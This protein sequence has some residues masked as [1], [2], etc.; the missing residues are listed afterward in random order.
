MDLRKISTGILMAALVAGESV[1]GPLD[2]P[3]DDKLTGE[4]IKA[5]WFT[6][7][8]FIATAPDGTAYRFVFQPD[9]HATK[10]PV[11][12]APAAKK[13]PAISGFWRIIAEGYCVRWTG[14][15]REKCF[16]IRKEGDTTVARF[17][18]V[19]MANWAK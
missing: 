3:A 18:K 16:N 2:K 9:G 5:T 8:P 10:M 4:A 1:A 19:V 13:G 14:S 6:G 11:P 15:V 7:Q 12:K 17:G